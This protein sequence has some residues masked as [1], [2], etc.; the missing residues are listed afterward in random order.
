[1]KDR[2]IH[3][4][5]IYRNRVEHD[6][7]VNIN[8]L[9]MP[10][11][12]RRAIAG[13]AKLCE[14]YPD[15]RSDELRAAIG[16]LCGVPPER[17][18]VGNGSSELMMAV[19]QAIKPAKTV[20]PVPS[21]YGYERAALAPEG[22]IVFFMPEDGNEN[23]DPSRRS[24]ILT[25]ESTRQLELALTGDVSLL[26][27]ANPNNPT[28]GC[29]PGG[30]LGTLLDHC[31]EYDI[32]VVLDECFLEFAADGAERTCLMRMDRWPNLIVLR[33]FTKICA[34][35]GVRLGWMACA[36]GKMLERTAAELPEWNVS[37]PAQQAGL[38]AVEALRDTSYLG[39]TLRTVG[40]EREYLA[41]GLKNLGLTVF[42]SDADFL[43][44]YS[45]KPLAGELLER[46]IMIR[47]C[48]NFRGLTEGFYRTAVK[49]REEN[50]L[51]LA[52]LD[53]IL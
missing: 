42:P 26:F 34:M 7:S 33:A 4:G 8:P 49:K 50:E 11:G 53:E 41:G 12:V 14:H 21:F 22:E 15:I 24:F 10:D 3:G 43:L 45:D 9:G 47:D 29:I 44:F 28:G 40:E 51:L 25:E 27:L 16:D 17:I 2:T 32:T 20:I 23:E 39:D 36:D 6:F 35:P 48:E 52:A 31:L 5:D 46:G 30:P 1:M 18:I 38:A 19:V 13:S 37:V